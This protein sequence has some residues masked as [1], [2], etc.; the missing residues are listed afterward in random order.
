[1]P[2]VAWMKMFHQTHATEAR[3]IFAAL[4]AP[5]GLT[6]VLEWLVPT[7]VLHLVQNSLPLIHASELRR[8]IERTQED[9]TLA[10]P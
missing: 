1:M 2:A 7:P 10:L 3:M 6:L 5:S 4:Q 9:R 8:A